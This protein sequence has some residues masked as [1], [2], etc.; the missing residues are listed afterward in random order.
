[1]GVV[2]EEDRDQR[3]AS[4]RRRT[5]P[6]DRL[7]SVA[8]CARNAMASPSRAAFRRAASTI[9][10]PQVSVVVCPPIDPLHP[11]AP[12]AAFDW[13]PAARGGPGSGTLGLPS[14]PATALSRR[15]S[16]LSGSGQAGKTCP[17]RL[18]KH[19]LNRLSS[20]RDAI[21]CGSREST[22]RTSNTLVRMSVRR[23]RHGRHPR[24]GK[25]T[26]LYRNPCGRIHAHDRLPDRLFLDKEC[27]RRFPLPLPPM[28]RARF[29]LNRS[30]S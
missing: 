4:T 8:L 15:L 1:M 5:C 17:P 12:S 6:A 24:E 7:R 14:P 16:R 28:N 30:C 26:T 13:T 22:G 9:Q 20:L 10:G 18:E 2:V 25:G 19:A 27:T 11:P 21:S 29:S 23:S 3:V